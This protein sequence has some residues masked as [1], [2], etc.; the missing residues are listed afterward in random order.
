MF[1]RKV[2]FTKKKIY[3]LRNIIYHVIYLLFRSA[4]FRS[5]ND[6]FYKNGM[7]IV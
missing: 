1:K 4:R 2:Y 5:K 6:G 3:G 7:F